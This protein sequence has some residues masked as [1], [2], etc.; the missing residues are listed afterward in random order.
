MV[1]F[2]P[3]R[4][5]NRLPIYVGKIPNKDALIDRVGNEYIHNV[6]KQPLLDKQGDGMKSYTRILLRLL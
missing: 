2:D 6:R 1:C 4:G 5:G 3:F